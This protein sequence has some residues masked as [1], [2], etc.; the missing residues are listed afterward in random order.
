MKKNS[1]K[2][3]IMQKGEKSEK[4]E[5]GKR[6]GLRQIILDVIAG[7]GPRNHIFIF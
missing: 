4:M 3:K 1:K 2:R 6:W 5:G 7:K